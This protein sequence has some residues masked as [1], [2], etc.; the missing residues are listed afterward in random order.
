MKKIIIGNWKMNPASLK[1]A[2]KLFTDVAKSLPT[3]KKTEVIICPPFLYLERLKKLG[4]KIAL[5]A[6]D[7]FWGDVGAFT[8]EVSADML[9]NLG[10]K[11]VILGHSERRALGE[12]DEDVNKKLKAALSAA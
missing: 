6:Q 2:E 7:A 10:V 9:S 12:T 5:G 11:Y 8:G 1:E 3:I 4:R